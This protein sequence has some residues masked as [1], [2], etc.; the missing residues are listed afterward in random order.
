MNFEK[1]ND[2]VSKSMTKNLSFHKLYN[3]KTLTYNPKVL[4]LCFW[5]LKC[6]CKA[7][8]DAPIAI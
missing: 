4:F 7:P 8:L 6:L 3:F 1:T 5:N 2:K